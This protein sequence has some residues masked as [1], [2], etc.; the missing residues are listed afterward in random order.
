MLDELV[1]RKMSVF[2]MSSQ[3]PR[4]KI[5]RKQLQSGLNPRAVKSYKDILER[6]RD[7]LLCN[8]ETSPDNYILHLQR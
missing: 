4:F 1:N 7:T 3:H 2:N 5:Y 6:E 8:L